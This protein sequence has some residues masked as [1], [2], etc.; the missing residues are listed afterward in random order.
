MEG[1]CWLEHV[2]AA[3]ENEAVGGLGGSERSR[4][5]FVVLEYFGVPQCDRCTG[6][7][8]HMG[9][10]PPHQV[11][12]EIDQ[13]L[14]G[15]GGPDLDRS[16][17]FLSAGGG[18]DVGSQSA[19]VEFRPVYAGPRLIGKAALQPILGIAPCVDSLTVVEI[20]EHHGRRSS[21]PAFVGHDGLDI[22]IGKL[23]LELGEGCQL[24]T[25]DGPAAAP[26][27]PSAEPTIAQRNTEHRTWLKK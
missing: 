11:L 14:A 8:L 20:V 15:W 18:T 1:E 3:A 24:P 17:L 12:P 6:R 16:K 23:D 5:Q 27:E 2:V 26:A 10:H 4:A 7:A 9:L 25:V 22:A 21:R 19:E 13:G